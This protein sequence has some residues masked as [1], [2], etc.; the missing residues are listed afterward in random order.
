LSSATS[1]SRRPPLPLGPAADYLAITERHL[2][3]LVYR[4][5]VPYTRVGRLLRFMPDDLDAYL[6]A[7]TIRAA[8]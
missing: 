3:E 2:R 8:S 6:D 4:R 5:E 1:T 7:R